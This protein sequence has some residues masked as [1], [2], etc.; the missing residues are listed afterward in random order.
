M[1]FVIKEDLRI[2]WPIKVSIP[3]DGGTFQD[4]EFI[5]VFNRQS[6]AQLHE[7]ANSAG[8]DDLGLPEMLAANVGKFA[9][10]L[11][12]WSGVKDTAG[13][14]VPFSMEVLRKLV[15]GPDGAAF[16]RGIWTALNELAYGVREKN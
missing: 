1:A 16:S 15:T 4:F 14:A 7:L 2:Q 8:L 11:T 3:A 12:D 6:P 9:G 5:G 13:Q 10:V